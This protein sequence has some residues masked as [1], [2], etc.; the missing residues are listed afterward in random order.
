MPRLVFLTCLAACFVPFAAAQTVNVTAG[1]LASES[2]LSLTAEDQ[3][4]PLD[5][6]AVKVD[7]SSEPRLGAQF[8]LRQSWFL[9]ASSTVD[10]WWA[11]GFARKQ[12]AFESGLQASIRVGPVFVE[13][14]RSW[15]PDGAATFP[16][17][18]GRALD[19]GGRYDRLELRLR[20]RPELLT[21]VRYER[22]ATTQALT[23]PVS[24]P[25]LVSRDTAGLAAVTMRLKPGGA[26]DVGLALG[27]ET[28]RR[29]GAS[30]SLRHWALLAD[31]PAGSQFCPGF[32][33]RMAF[34][35][36][37]QRLVW[38]ASTAGTPASPEMGRL[39]LTLEREAVT[40]TVV[41]RDDQSV[42]A[43]LSARFTFG[44]ASRLD[45]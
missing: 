30:V 35:A 37:S 20:G 40:G 15:Q 5:R 17:A 21:T 4:G 45:W 36:G 44:A 25:R 24:A 39:A 8:T 38:Q 26:S 31:R 22:D 27:I 13:G 1:L 16:T 43:E 41:M 2:A 42:E 23:V 34:D 12:D 28:N 10:A 33:A 19:Q 18:G 32:D 29:R 14:E 6:L 9:G 3:L 11:S 7:A